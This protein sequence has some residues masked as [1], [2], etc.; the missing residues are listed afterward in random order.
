M[1]LE[2]GRYWQIHSQYHQ[3]FHRQQVGSA[4]TDGLSYPKRPLV[5]VPSVV[6]PLLYLGCFIPRFTRLGISRHIGPRKR[7]RN[8]AQ[9]RRRTNHAGPDVC[10]KG[11]TTQCVRAHPCKYGWTKR[12]WRATDRQPGA[13]RLFSSIAVAARVSLHRIQV[14]LWRNAG[15]PVRPPRMTRASARTGSS[16]RNQKSCRPRTGQLFPVKGT[17]IFYPI[18]FENN[19]HYWASLRSTL[20]SRPIRRRFWGDFG[21]PA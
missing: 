6:S 15:Q 17:S 4:T 11:C 18:S 12:C 21:C 1:P 9:D 14:C 19:S 16:R 7:K 5:W 20:I 13:R 8:W 10:A 3:L 2:R